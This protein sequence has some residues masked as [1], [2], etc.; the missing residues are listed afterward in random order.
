MNTPPIQWYGEFTLNPQTTTPKYVLTK[1]S[2]YYPVIE[3]LKGRDKK[4]SLFLMESTKSGSKDSITTPPM[5][6]QAKGSLNL[7]G[8]KYYFIEGKLSGYACGN[9][10]HKETYRCNGKDK[11]NPFY[12]NRNDGF[13]FIFKNESGNPVPSS[14]EMIVLSNARPVIASYLQMLRVGGFND[15]LESMRTQATAN[16]LSPI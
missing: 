9:P 1:E 15:V 14:F 8:L 6:L 5:K 16:L 11:T 10:Y 13:L 12:E 4:I 2:G 3:N 7:T